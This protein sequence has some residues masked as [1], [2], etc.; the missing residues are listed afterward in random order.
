M[1]EYFGAFSGTLESPGLEFPRGDHKDI[2]YFICQF[3][4]LRDLKLHSV[5]VH[6]RPMYVRGPP[7]DIKTSPPL[8]GTLDLRLAMDNGRRGDSTGAQLIL[9]HLLR[10]PSGLNF[11]T[12][13]LSGYIGNN[14]QPL[15]DACVPTL[16]Y[17]DLNLEGLCAPFLHR[18]K[19][20]W[21]I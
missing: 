14:L 2:F 5:G 3:P 11:R 1:E 18:E 21:F 4:N 16:K 17:M 19:C 10:L 7:F 12:L 9:S 15:A 13:K 8:D 20:P 6:T